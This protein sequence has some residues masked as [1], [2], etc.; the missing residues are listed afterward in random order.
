M[1]S[2][3]FRNNPLFLR[4][5]FKSVGIFDMPIIRKQNTSLK[6]IKLG[7]SKAQQEE[8]HRAISPEGLGSNELFSFAQEFFDK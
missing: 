1:T 3:E 6:D 4:N 7:L 8:L 5:Q 2:E